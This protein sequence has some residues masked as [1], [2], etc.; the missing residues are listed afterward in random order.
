MTAD[1]I[2]RRKLSHEV[3][4]RLLERLRNGEWRPGEPLPSERDLMER[5]GVGRPAIREAMQTLAHSGIIEI[6]HGGRARVRVPTAQS[7]IDQIAGGAQHLLRTE[8]ETLEHLKQARVFLEAGLARIAAE[9]ASADDVARLRQCLER[10][11]SA[12]PAVDQFLDCDMAFH[13]EIAAISGNPIFPAIVEAMFQWAKEFYV[14]IVRAPG[15][16]SLTLAEHE[17]IILALAAHD[18]A[19]AEQAM[20]DHLMRANDLYRT[21]DRSGPAIGV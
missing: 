9:R 18:C 14:A 11:K 6:A 4:D 21:L 20:R 12:L 10:Q 17:S 13:R 5:F 7:L 1:R 16:E 15:A 8:P 3:H 19:A 2:Q